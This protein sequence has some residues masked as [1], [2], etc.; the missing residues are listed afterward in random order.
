MVECHHDAPAFGEPVCPHLQA[1]AKPGMKYVRW[2]LGV[3][4][5]ADLLCETCAAR[6]GE[7]AQPEVLRVCQGCHERV[8]DE[9]GVC[10][11]F[12]GS[13]GIRER[14]VPM[15]FSLRRSELPKQFGKVADLVAISE[16]AR[17]LWLLLFDGGALV[18]WD[19]DSGETVPVAQHR[20]A[21]GEQP[22]SKSRPRL[23]AST[24]G[25]FAAV[26]AD[27]GRYGTV[28]DLRSGKE[29]LRLDGGDYH[30]ETVPLSF[31]FAEVDGRI[32]AVH[33]SDWCRLDLSDPA[34]GELL[35]K[36]EFAASGKEEEEAPHALDYFHGALY[37][38]PDGRHVL[39]DGWVWHPVGIPTVWDL[40]RWRMDNPWESE[41]GPSRLSL[42]VRSYCWDRSMTWIDDRRIALEGIGDD[43]LRMLPGARIF[44]ITQPPPPEEEQGMPGSKGAKE[45][46]SFPGP[47]G[48]FFGGRGILYSADEKGLS[49]WDPSTGDRLGHLPGFSPTH[50]HVGTNALAGIVDGVLVRWTCPVSIPV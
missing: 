31:A 22:E 5:D 9:V 12:R 13:P 16:G 28:L 29:T 21:G 19:A 35:S 8:C 30:P 7:G 6:R 1:C 36:R 39:D 34:T 24:R 14:P 10:V 33:R 48:G 42:C 37:V 15:D 46:L 45:L 43:D 2:F 3:N 47:T 40:E 25:E 44:D 11:G 41:D 27:Y 26:C 23:H 20:L 49:V 17:S 18:R 50:Q 32:L 38:S 4:M